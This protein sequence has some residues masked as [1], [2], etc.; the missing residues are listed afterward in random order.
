M[1]IGY[2]TS[3]KVYSWMHCQWWPITNICA[4]ILL[5][6]SNFTVLPHIK[7]FFAINTDILYA[8]KTSLKLV[9]WFP[10]PPILMRIIL[11][12]HITFR[13]NTDCII[14]WLHIKRI[15]MNY[16][17]NI[18]T[19]ESTVPLTDNV[20]LTHYP[21]CSIRNDQ[22]TYVNSGHSIIYAGWV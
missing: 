10:W 11:T 22:A 2:W 13:N 17:F 8:K 14:E 21:A 3:L 5:C 9:H 6:L 15:L 1:Y 7:L 19:S 12:F 20:T 16:P 4:N 18:F